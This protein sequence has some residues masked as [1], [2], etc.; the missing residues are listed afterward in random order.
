MTA[1]TREHKDQALE[2]IQSDPSLRHQ[3][4]RENG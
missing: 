1:V 3:E 4:Q 2:R